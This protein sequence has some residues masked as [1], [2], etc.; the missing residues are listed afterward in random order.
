LLLS[1]YEELIDLVSAVKKWRPYLLGNPFT[2]KT[3]HQSFKFMLEQKIGTPMQQRWV[4]K[5]LGYDFLVEY[6]KGQDNKVADAL[7]RRFEEDEPVV[8]LSV[9]SYPTLEWLKELKDSYLTDAHM[10]EIMQKFHAGVLSPQFSLRDDILLYKERLYIGP[11]LRATVLQF[12]HASPVAG[13]AW[14]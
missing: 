2:I 13:H 10:L 12:I 4:S 1:T 3:N 11:T 5:L 7:S 9:I 14:I 8:Q 6:K